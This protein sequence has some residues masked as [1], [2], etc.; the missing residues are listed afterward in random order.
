LLQARGA[1][2][3]DGGISPV[4][5]PVGSGRISGLVPTA[6][7]SSRRPMTTPLEEQDDGMI[8]IATYMSIVLLMDYFT[9]ATASTAACPPQ[10]LYIQK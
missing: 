8:G 3:V 4:I 9:E 6:A 1:A 2:S 10:L 5:D 7:P